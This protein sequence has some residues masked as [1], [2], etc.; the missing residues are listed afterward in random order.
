MA[1]FSVAGVGANRLFEYF[2]TTSTVIGLTVT[3]L[4]RD[5]KCNIL[6]CACAPYGF[7]FSS[8][9]PLQSVAVVLAEPD[10]VVERTND[11]I[12]EKEK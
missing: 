9:S 1:S 5:R 12:I 11:I 10:V 3:A 2:P 7:Y 8:F 4:P 6:H